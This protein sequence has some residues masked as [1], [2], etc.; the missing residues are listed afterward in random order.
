MLSSLTAS[1]A[2]SGFFD[3]ALFFVV[4]VD[5]RGTGS[6]QPSVRDSH[7]HM[8][9]YLDISIGQMSAD[10]ETARAHLGIERWLVFGGSWGSTLALAYA[11]SYPKQVSGLIL[12]GIFTLRRRE[13]EWFYQDGASRLFPDLWQDYLAPIP[14]AERGDL[15]G[16]YYRRLTGDDAQARQQAA[17]AWAVWEGSLS[18]LARDPNLVQKYGGD[19]FALAFARIEC[20][21]FVHGGWFE[22]DNQLLREARRLAGIPGVIVQGRY[23]VV[24]PAETAWLLNRAWPESRLVMVE[25][26]GHNS[27]EAGIA[28]A[29]VEATDAFR[30]GAY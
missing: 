19:S 17:I 26:A 3:P 2:W 14:P 16:A 21:Y 18:K 22:R 4:E 8:Q 6:S 7:T 24:C 1:G 10:F 27:R 12:R 15:M 5:Q 13:L 23:D 9:R 29:L 30:Q 25:D 20:H 11:Q 28:A